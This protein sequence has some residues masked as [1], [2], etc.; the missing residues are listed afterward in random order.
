MNR[1]M[2]YAV[3]LSPGT[4]EAAKPR[5]VNNDKND[6]RRRQQARRQGQ[7]KPAAR[8]P[9]A[10]VEVEL[11]ATAA[12]QQVAGAAEAADGVSDRVDYLA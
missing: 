1:E 12:A 6:R 11:T 5:V 10:D 7:A 9:Q 8:A 3:H 4:P 2:D